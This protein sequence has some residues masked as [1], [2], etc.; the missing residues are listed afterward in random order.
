MTTLEGKIFLNLKN[1]S[2]EMAGHSWLIGIYDGELSQIASEIASLFEGYYEK[3]FVEWLG[4]SG[5]YMN[6]IDNR[7]FYQRDN[8][9][10]K[11]KTTNELYTYW[12]KEVRHG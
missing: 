9:N 12:Q 5:Y 10:Y 6:Q 4:H 2:G 7:W 11:I 8:L 1:H 3:E